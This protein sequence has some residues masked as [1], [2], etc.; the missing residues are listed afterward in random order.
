MSKYLV[1]VILFLM[2]ATKLSYSDSEDFPY[3]I[4]EAARAFEIKPSLLYSI[5]HVE[6]NCRARAVNHYDSIKDGEGRR[7]Y[8]PSRGLFQLKLG[9][10]RSLGYTGPANGLYDPETNAFYAAKLFKQNLVKYKTHVKAISAHNA[11]RYTASN[12]AYVNKVLQ[13]YSYLT[14]DRGFE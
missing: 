9:T 7:R 11:G 2:F 8:S 14:L 1:L 3:Y 13:Y 5:C 4:M 10:A 6:S 12:V